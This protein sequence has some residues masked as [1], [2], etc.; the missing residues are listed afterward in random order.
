[1]S[2][3]QSFVVGDVTEVLKTI[4]HI[5][6]SHWKKGGTGSAAELALGKDIVEEFRQYFTVK[7]SHSA[8]KLS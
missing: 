8:L 5:D 2:Q 7:G 6:V 1:L 3:K 4:E